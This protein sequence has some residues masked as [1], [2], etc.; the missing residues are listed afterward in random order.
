MTERMAQVEWQDPTGKVHRSPAH[1]WR[2]DKARWQPGKYYLRGPG[3]L[4]LRLLWLA[5][6]LRWGL[7]QNSLTLLGMRAS[8]TRTDYGQWKLE[9]YGTVMGLSLLFYLGSRHLFPAI[10]D[11]C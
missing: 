8:V 3:Y 9:V 2:E 4:R 11:R 6:A 5:C 7:G 1:R 10:P